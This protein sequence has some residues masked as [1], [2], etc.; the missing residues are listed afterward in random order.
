VHRFP[1]PQGQARTLSHRDGVNDFRL[2]RRDLHGFNAA[3]PGTDL[4]G[5][6]RLSKARELGWIV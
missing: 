3:V 6:S 1:T 5:M 2:Y 4:R